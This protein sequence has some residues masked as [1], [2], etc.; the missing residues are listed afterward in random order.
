ML[1]LL[2][3]ET[4]E[5]K[6]FPLGWWGVVVVMDLMSEEAEKHHFFG[7]EPQTDEM[8]IWLTWTSL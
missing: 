5:N 2:G 6:S 8:N 7:A 1:D 4:R 3:D